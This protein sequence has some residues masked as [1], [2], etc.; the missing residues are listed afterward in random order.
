MKTLRLEIA[1]NFKKFQPRWR[2]Q[3]DKITDVLRANPKYLESYQRITTLQAWRS[4]LFEGRI[5]SNAVA[6]FLEAQNDGLTSHIF[7]QLGCWRSALKSL[8]SCLENTYQCL[9][10]MDH[11]VE[12]ELWHSGHHRLSRIEL[13]RYLEQHPQIRG[14]DTNLSGIPTLSE[15]YETLSKAVHASAKGFRMT[16]DSDTV[17][18][19]SND[20]ASAGRWA[21]RERQVIVGINLLLMMM[22]RKYIQGTQKPNLR[23]SISLVIPVTKH[24]QIKTDLGVTLYK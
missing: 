22:F 20:S 1:S 10:Y 23:K 9:Y 3:L 7:A 16:E 4:E 17:S 14:N 6:F 8:R 21:T 5:D 2:A 13:Q 15:E 18:L 19:F 12:L 24:T 11:P